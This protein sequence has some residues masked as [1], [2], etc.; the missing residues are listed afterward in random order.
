MAHKTG[1][2]ALELSPMS[3]T[4]E[5]HLRGGHDIAAF[6]ITGDLPD[7]AVE[8]VVEKLLQVVKGGPNR[9]EVVFEGADYVGELMITACIGAYAELKRRGGCFLWSWHRSDLR[10]VSEYMRRLLGRGGDDGLAGSTARLQPPPSF[11]VGGS[12]RGL[13]E[14]EPS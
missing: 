11:D 9:V 4:Y 13:P 8:P 12:A 7:Q 5:V 1:S 10:M 14:D 2:G 3:F 6:Q